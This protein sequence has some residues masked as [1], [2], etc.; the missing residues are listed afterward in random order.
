MDWNNVEKKEAAAGRKGKA[1][2]GGRERGGFILNPMS[3][4]VL[5][6]MQVPYWWWW[7]VVF[8][9]V[10]SVRLILGHGADGTAS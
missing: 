10:A 5:S 7:F 6:I 4:I 3:E 1:A 2:E 9:H 8:R